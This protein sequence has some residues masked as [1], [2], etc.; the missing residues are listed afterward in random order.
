MGNHFVLIHG[1]W[2]GGWC[3][4]GVIEKLE[5]A[6]HTAEAPTM[7]G[8]NPDDDRSGI[9][10]EDYVNKIVSVLKKQAS[11]VV[12][13]GHSSAGFLLQAAAPKAADKI[14]HLIFL[15]TFI[16]PN[17]KRQFDLVPPEVSQGMTA[18]ANAS[19]DN[20]VPVDERFVRNML[21]AGETVEKQDSLISRLVPQPIAIFTTPVDTGNFDKLTIPKSVVFCKADASLPPGAYLAMAHELGKY[22]LVE[23]EGGHELLFT[24]PGAVAEGLQQALK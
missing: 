10:F 15:N 17:G 13:V 19:P 7:P 12:L 21:M 18:A 3:W 2:H 4:D 11:P 14:S 6:G 23:L 5:K 1:A 8:H 24:D 20:C 16:L 22:N 9:R